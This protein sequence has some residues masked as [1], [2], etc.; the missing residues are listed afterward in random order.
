MGT[1]TPTDSIPELQS[2]QPFHSATAATAAASCFHNG[3]KMTI[4]DFLL[5]AI[6]FFMTPNCE[7][8]VERTDDKYSYFCFSFFN[9]S[10]WV[11]VCVW[12]GEGML[13]WLVWLPVHS[14]A[15]KTQT[16]KKKKQKKKK[17]TQ[18]KNTK[19]NK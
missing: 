2:R 15:S 9:F 19:E 11:A 13:V 8:T 3:D 12:V 5:T 16:K 18:K 14:I 6:V 1:V 10:A 17:K 4:A 7:V